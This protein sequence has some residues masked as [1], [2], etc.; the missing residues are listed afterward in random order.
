MFVFVFLLV[1]KK[2]QATKDDVEK[3]QTGLEDL[4]FFQTQKQDCGAL[5]YVHVFLFSDTWL[6]GVTP[7]DAHTLSQTHT[8]T[9]TYSFTC[10][11]MCH[12]PPWSNQPLCRDPE[13]FG[14]TLLLAT[15]HTPSS[16]LSRAAWLAVLFSFFSISA[17]DE[18]T[19]T[20]R[21]MCI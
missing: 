14:H 11:T 20:H 21:I 5:L 12:H 3:L 17:S 7:L 8:N 10:Q 16:L 13:R 6:R 15:L 9:H 2:M 18:K 19:H 4:R 1:Y